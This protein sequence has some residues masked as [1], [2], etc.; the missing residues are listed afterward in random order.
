MEHGKCSAVFIM[1]NKLQSCEI[2]LLLLLLIII[3]MI[4]IVSS[5]TGTMVG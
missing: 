1:L 5:V 4:I 3:I 2:S